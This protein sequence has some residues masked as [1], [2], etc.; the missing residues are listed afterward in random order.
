MHW[1][2][3]PD[4][5]LSRLAFQRGLAAIYL[6]GFLVAANQFR[7]LLGTNGLL[8][9]PRYVARVPMRHS[10]S[11]FHLRYSDRFFALVAWSGAALAAAT[12][13][14]LAD[15]GP[16]WTSLLIW[17]GLWVLYLSIVNVG[18]TWYGFGWESLLLETGFLA[19]FLGNARVAPPVLLLWLLRWL[20]FRV[21]FGAG[22][23]K[24][25]GD[26]CWRDLTCL[27]YHH[28]TQPM[29]GPFSWYFHRL[30]DPLHR[31]EVAANHVAQLGVPFLLFTP[32]P[33]ATVAALLL[34]VTQL[35]LVAS[36]NFAWL[37]W[38]T[39]VIAVSTVDGS[40]VAHPPHFAATPGWYQGV[41]ITVAALLVALSYRP[42]GNLLSRRQIMNYSFDPLHLVNTY[43]AFGSISRQRDE[44]VLEGTA[45]A[46]IGA[47]T[48]WREYEFKGKPGDPKR[49]P[50]QVAPYHLRLDWLMW[51]LPL[52]PRYGATW[53][54]GLLGKLLVNDRSLLRLLRGNPFPD[55]PPVHV[56]AVMYRYRYTTR[57][58]RRA[59]GAWWSRTELREL[60]APVSLEQ[61]RRVS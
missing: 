24:L 44:V 1:F 19:I 37:N 56:R 6:I 60:I 16:L 58:E 40:L 35:W 61:L 5:W 59:T 53:L 22:L 30:P 42:A 14:G 50:P 3:A 15:V 43:G 12:V 33:V 55:A 25:R 31:V 17:A 48:T 47:E 18:Q 52:S 57:A 21:E 54:A 29:P 39:I 28:E 51:F 38:L 4:Y 34:I 26:R 23:I 13:A 49:R 32:Q 11:L 45:D 36:G 10:P 41:V 46:S 20:L 8:P 9:I 7:A 27:R 2:D